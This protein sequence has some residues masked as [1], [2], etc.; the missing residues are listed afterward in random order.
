[1]RFFFVLILFCFLC[2]VTIVESLSCDHGLGL[3]ECV[4]VTN[5]HRGLIPEAGDVGFLGV[6]FSGLLN[7][8]LPLLVYDGCYNSISAGRAL[9]NV[10]RSFYGDL[11]RM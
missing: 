9:A 5:T 11:L 6:P 3:K 10:T 1:M 2:F 7:P 4:N 8:P